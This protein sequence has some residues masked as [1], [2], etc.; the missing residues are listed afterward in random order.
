MENSHNSNNNNADEAKTSSVCKY[1]TLAISWS[2]KRLSDLLR[3][4]KGIGLWLVYTL[5]IDIELKFG[6]AEYE[7]TSWRHLA[8]KFLF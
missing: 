7:T 5:S 1:N 2:R 3:L 6:S 4:S 8:N